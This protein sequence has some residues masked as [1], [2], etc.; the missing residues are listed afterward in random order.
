M[1]VKSMN[2]E[3]RERIKRINRGEVPEG[4][5]RTK[6]GLIPENWDIKK[7]NSVLKRVRNAVKVKN[8]TCYQQIGIRSHGKGIFYKEHVTGFELGN[9]SVFW[10]EPNCFIVN[11]V[12]AWEM[13]V[14]KTTENEI[15]MIASHRFPMY[16]VVNT[17][18]DLDYLTYFFKSTLGKE[19]LGLA[20]PGGAG[21]NKTL[22]QQE[23]SE[24]DIPLPVSVLEQKKIAT[25]LSTWDKAIELKEKLIEQQKGQKRGLMQK[26]LTGKVRL[27][28]FNGEWKKLKL[29]QVVDK[30]V[31]G[32]TPAKERQ[33]YYDGD[34]P[35]ASV[36]DLSSDVD[37]K[38]DTIDHITELGLANSSTKIV[39]KGNFIISTRMGL[40]R[41]IINTVD[42]AINQDLK[43]IYVNKSMIGVQYLMYWYKSMDESIMSLGIGSTVKG[44]DLNTL[45]NLVI[46]LPPIDEQKTITKVFGL[47]DQEITLYQQQLSLLKQQ[48][49]G[50][51]QLLLTGK[52]R[53]SC[54]N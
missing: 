48:K 51:M 27:S 14:A 2:S 12:F 26:L 8:E 36:K 35:W 28:G 37:Y 9:K 20:S 7:V 3:I 5:K 38:D 34:I 42:M 24:L 30:I 40:G 44:I 52:V 46:L 13:A 49:K 29:G 22:G 50:L 6:R 10:I 15:G 31:G 19:L 11:I 25:I 47:L 18:L 23:F 16:K 43:G 4:Y 17:N 45:S 53:V 39:A 32:G 41:G 54:E 33:E 21:R 1:R